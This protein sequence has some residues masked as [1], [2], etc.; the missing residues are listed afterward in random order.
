[1]T[2]ESKSVIAAQQV[3]FARLTSPE[4][5]TKSSFSIVCLIA[6]LVETS[7]RI[8]RKQRGWPSLLLRRHDANWCESEKDA[9]IHSKNGAETHIYD[10]W[11]QRAAPKNTYE[12]ATI[13]RTR[14]KT[15]QLRW[16][17]KWKVAATE[18]KSTKRISKKSWPSRM[19]LHSTSKH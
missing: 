9:A 19:T 10:S 2:R 5:R 11:Q 15:R 18:T 6:I 12:D 1:M 14:K 13:N 16:S 8:W 3:L 7:K 17:V 4:M